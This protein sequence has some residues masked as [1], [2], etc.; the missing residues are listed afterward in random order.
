MPFK[1]IS[2]IEIIA[3]KMFKKYEKHKYHFSI[4]INS[5]ISKKNLYFLRVLEHLYPQCI[6]IICNWFKNLNKKIC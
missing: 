5:T 3:L 4:K 6:S 2:I 1:E